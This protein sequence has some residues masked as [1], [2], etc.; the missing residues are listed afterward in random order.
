MCLGG[1]GPSEAEK[2]AARAQREEAAEAK[3]QEIE[4]AARQKREDIDVALTR[5]TAR[6]GRTGG[7]GTRSLFTG[8]GSGYFSRFS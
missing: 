7:A 4:K 5:T 3:R 2:E 1:G 8:T 6:E